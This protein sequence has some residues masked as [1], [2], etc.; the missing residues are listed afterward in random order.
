MLSRSESH[1]QDK[2]KRKKRL[3]RLI[4]INFAL[5]GVIIVILG[6]W[7][8][9]SV[10]QSK[11]EA[12]GD[13]VNDGQTADATDP[14]ADEGS[15]NSKGSDNSQGSDN[16]GNNIGNSTNG[17]PE[18]DGENGTVPGTEGSPDETVSLSFVGDLLLGEYV[19]PVM[20][21]EGYDFLYKKSLLYLSEPDL[22]AGNLEH[23]VT[24]GGVPV[25]GTPYVF[26]GSPDA[27]PALRE[28]GFDVVSLAN[29]HALDQGVEGMLDTMKHLEEAG[30]SHMGAGRDD[31]EAF[32]PVIKEV[33]GIKIAYIG[34]SR[35][36]P[37]ASWK[38]DKNVAGVA[39]TY[40]TKRAVAAIAKAKDQADIVVVMVHWGKERVDQ[41]EPYQKDFAR[42]Y[43]DAGA[44]L[45][46]GSHPHVLQGFEMYKGKWIAYS[47]GNFIF[48][49][50]PKGTA[51]ETGVLDAVCTKSGDCDMTFHPMFTVN[52]QPT[53]LETDAAKALL[54]RL[55]AISF[56]VKLREDGSIVPD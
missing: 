46:I 4:V 5:L 34:I 47:L 35:V 41:P 14:P 27:L 2:L 54:D 32:S 39:E 13:P 36:V 52:A 56:Q 30:I 48:T 26:K 45:V 6:A 17:T 8:A 37:F 19:D 10:I 12:G 44:D 51:G 53:P 15:G 29:N 33:R 7:L 11:P 16:N 23:P 1:Q 38:A 21:R 3:R 28:A 31:T 18:D 24:S 22:T 25:E 40:E 42:Q 55:S 50:F 43:I 49:A 9:A 20:Q